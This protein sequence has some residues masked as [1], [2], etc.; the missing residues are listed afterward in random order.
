MGVDFNNYSRGMGHAREVCPI[1][2]AKK[3]GS[4]NSGNDT[5][6]HFL[7][8]KILER[9]KKSGLENIEVDFAPKTPYPVI[10]VICF[11]NLVLG[12]TDGRT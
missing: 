10:V 1:A 2:E 9:R 4:F 8:S 7:K 11:H 5:V 3:S 12:P 6:K